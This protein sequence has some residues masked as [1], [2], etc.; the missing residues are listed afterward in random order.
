M[1]D[2]TPQVKPMPVPEATEAEMKDQEPGP[3]AQKREDLMKEEQ[4]KKEET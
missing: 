3:A 4:I 2:K 1:F